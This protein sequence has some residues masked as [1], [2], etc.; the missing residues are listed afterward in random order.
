[1]KGIYISDSTDSCERNAKTGVGNKIKGQIGAF[2]GLGIQCKNH[3]VQREELKVWNK[4]QK[5]LFVFGDGLDWMIT[6]EIQKADFV[7]IRKPTPISHDFIEFLR[8]VRLKN[9]H[10][11]ILMELPTYPYDKEFIHYWHRFPLLLQDRRWRKKLPLYLD[12][13]VTLE[14]SEKIFGVEALSISNGIDL[15]AYR[16]KKQNDT[17][18]FNIGCVAQ[19]EFWHGIDRL[20]CG[21]AEYQKEGSRKVHIYLAGEGTQLNALKELTKEYHLESFVTFLGALNRKQLYEQLYDRCDIAIEGLGIHRKDKKLVSSSLKSR[22]YLAVGIP[23][24]TSGCD[25][26]KD[27]AADFCFRASPDE[28]PT[29]IK[30]LMAFY[31]NLMQKETKAQL[32]KRI[33]EYA[34]NK[35]SWEKSMESVIRWLTEQGCGG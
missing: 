32:T 24:V 16:E 18:S 19:L 2:R 15:S 35:V 7:Y 26:A 27:E 11:K 10:C 33:R 25:I 6:E 34:Q 22:E 4:L 17:D 1:M 8:K 12:R 30:A 29:N 20:I 5:R 23:F 21:M 14:S 9:L 13:I 28:T 3:C 31:D